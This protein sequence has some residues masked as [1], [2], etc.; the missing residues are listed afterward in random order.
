M[1]QQNN[2]YAVTG[3]VNGKKHI[4]GYIQSPGNA[5]LFASIMQKSYTNV[6]VSKEKKNHF[7]HTE[8]F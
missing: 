8:P 5:N 2:T 3:E 1:K 6:Q 4:L 7:P